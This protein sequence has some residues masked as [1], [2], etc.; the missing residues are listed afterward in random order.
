MIRRKHQTLMV[1]VSFGFEEHT[2]TL[3]ALLT[4]TPMMI[5]AGKREKIQNVSIKCAE[6]FHPHQTN[7]FFYSAE[8]QIEKKKALRINHFLTVTMYK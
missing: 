8:N 1:S 6:Q 7:I 5:D 3:I 2:L 4:D